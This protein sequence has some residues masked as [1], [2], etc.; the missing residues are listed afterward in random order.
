MPSKIKKKKNFVELRV[1]D[2][3]CGIPEDAIPRLF[4]KFYQVDASMTRKHGGT[5]LGLPIV[6]HIIDLH[7]G[8]IEVKSIINKGS[9]FIIELPIENK[10]IKK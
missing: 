9:E 2:N 8:T 3:G 10:E 6:K 4:D 5:G 1:K 7:K